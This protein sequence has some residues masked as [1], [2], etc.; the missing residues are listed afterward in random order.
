QEACEARGCAW[1]PTDMPNAPWCFFPQDSPYGY[2]LGRSIQKTAKGWRITLN[3][4]QA[5]SLFGNDITPIVLEV[6]F[7]TKDRLRFRLYDPNRERFEVPL[8]IDSPGVTA[9]EA[10]YDVEF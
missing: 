1:C 8:K 4:R 2:S 5:L 7:Q 3:K 6:E 9:D 10:S